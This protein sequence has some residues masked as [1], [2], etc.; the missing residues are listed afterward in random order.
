MIQHRQEDPIVLENNRGR[1]TKVKM[2]QKMNQCVVTS[3]QTVLFVDIN[4]KHV[5]FSFCEKII[6]EILSRNKLD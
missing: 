6:N 1:K 2:N 4:N 3:Q 5:H